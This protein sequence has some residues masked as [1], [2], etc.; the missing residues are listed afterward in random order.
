MDLT[1][2]L[3]SYIKGKKISKKKRKRGEFIRNR[4]PRRARGYG[5]RG[6][7]YYNSKNKSDRDNID[8]Q[9]LA[10][11]TTLTKQNQTTLDLS[12]PEDRAKYAEYRKK[13]DAGA[14]EINLNK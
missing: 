7:K 14:I 11:L 10:L 1:D 6:S 8:K 3:N 2:Y 12:K 5:Q 4:I 13:R 9:L